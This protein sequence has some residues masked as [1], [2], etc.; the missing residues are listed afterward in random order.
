M[1]IKLILAIFFILTSTLVNAQGLTYQL[2]DKELLLTPKL[3]KQVQ[4]DANNP[5]V[6][7][8]SLTEQ[9]LKE[10][11]QLIHNSYDKKLNIIFNGEVVSLAVSIKITELASPT[12]YLTTDNE[13]LAIAILRYFT[14]NQ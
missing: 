1:A 10:F 14:P 7:K 12:F 2:I 11:N 6:L 4:L 9:G 13:Q 3:I 8:L 5:K